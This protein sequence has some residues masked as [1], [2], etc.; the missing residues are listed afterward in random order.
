MYLIL[1]ALHIYDKVVYICW[2][3]CGIKGV[4][5]LLLIVLCD[6]EKVVA[7]AHAEYL[8]EFV[9]DKSGVSPGTPLML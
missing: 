7:K 1:R 6:D 5:V 3:S 9:A 8:Y 2:Y 4:R